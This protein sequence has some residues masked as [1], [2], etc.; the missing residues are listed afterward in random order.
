MCG[1]A[2]IVFGDVDRP[3]ALDRLRAMSDT[4]RHRG[5]DEEGVHLRANVGLAIRRLAVIDPRGGHQPVHNEDQSVQVVFNGEIYNHRRLRSELARKGH[6]LL[7][8]CDSEIIPHLY[9]E[10]GTDF[11]THL[12]GMFAI[13]LWDRS[14]QQLVLTRDRLGVKPLYYSA[15]DGSLVFGSEIKALL[16]AEIKT[17]VDVQALS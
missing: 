13:A 7:S 5:P 2:G 3:V 12:E 4:L 8:G 9:E 6:R 1:I 15:Q 17:T 14:R 16:A 11:V 10:Y